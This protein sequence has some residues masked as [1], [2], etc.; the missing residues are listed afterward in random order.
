[1]SIEQDIQTVVQQRNVNGDII[2]ARARMQDAR[3]TLQT[4]LSELDIIKNAGT[5]NEAPADLKAALVDGY[6]AISNA[7]SSLDTGDI[8]TLLDYGA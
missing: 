5:I 4:V 1:M 7:A 2:K 6:N 3:M 8:K